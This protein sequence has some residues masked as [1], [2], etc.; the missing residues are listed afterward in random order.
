[1]IF[2]IY[3]F[4]EPLN[5]VLAIVCSNRPG[6]TSKTGICCNEIEPDDYLLHILKHIASVDTVEQLGALLPWNMKSKSQR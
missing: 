6:N 2:V 4:T 5:P 1:M 3:T